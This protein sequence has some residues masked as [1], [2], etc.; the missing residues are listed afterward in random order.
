[1]RKNEQ[2]VILNGS[3]KALGNCLDI[4]RL[5][6]LAMVIAEAEVNL[7]ESYC[8]FIGPLPP[9]PSTFDPIYSIDMKFG[10]YN[11]L[12]LYFQISGTTWCLNGFHVNESQINEVKAAVIL[13]F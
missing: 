8:L 11:K 4:V 2:N 5:L 1:M 12:H 9:P 10:M 7:P 3:S 6:V 13:D